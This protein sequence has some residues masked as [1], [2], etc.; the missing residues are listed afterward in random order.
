M[1][2]LCLYSIYV[3]LKSLARFGVGKVYDS[4]ESVLTIYLWQFRSISTT[5]VV[6]KSGSQWDKVGVNFFTIMHKHQ[7]VEVRRLWNGW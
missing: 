6:Y 4:C 1:L 7:M 3:S 2:H 5:T